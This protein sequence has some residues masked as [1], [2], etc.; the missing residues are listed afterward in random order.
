M[1]HEA[2]HASVFTGGIA[3]LASWLMMTTL[4]STG[5]VTTIMPSIADSATIPNKAITVVTN[6]FVPA[7][8]S[9][10]IEVTYSLTSDNN[11]NAFLYG[12]FE[13]SSSVTVKYEGTSLAAYKFSQATVKGK[14]YALDATVVSLAD[15]AI[16]FEQIVEAVKNEFDAGKTNINLT[17]AHDTDST[18]L[19]A[20][21]YGLAEAGYCSI[22]LTLMGCK[23]IPSKG[24]MRILL[25]Y[26]EKQI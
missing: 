26:M 11:G 6:K 22:N 18:V 2:I 25:K 17:L 19:D 1:R 24:F 14:S 9:G 4:L 10:P 8:G 20:I 12:N 5:F 21:H 15:E 13:E 3:A 23:K 7:Q 16:T